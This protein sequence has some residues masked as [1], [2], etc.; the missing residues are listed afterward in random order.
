MDSKEFAYFGT[1]IETTAMHEC[2]DLSSTG[3]AWSC[4]GAI[5]GLR[6]GPD[7]PYGFL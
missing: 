4:N 5:R 2:F 3:L 6:S 7:D 1:K